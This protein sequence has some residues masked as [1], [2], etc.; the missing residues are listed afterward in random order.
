MNDLTNIWL[1]PRVYPLKCYTNGE[2][3]PY[4]RKR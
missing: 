4:M 2:S 1:L 3:V